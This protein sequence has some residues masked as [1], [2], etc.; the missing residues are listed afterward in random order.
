MRIIVSPAK[1]MRVYTESPRPLGTP[2]FLGDAERI[3]AWMRTLP[4]PEVK[5]LWAASDAI[6]RP[7]YDRL[8]HLD[9]T[10]PAELTPA[11]LAYDGIA[12]AYMA[13]DVFSEQDFAYVDDHLL[14]LSGLYGVL[15]PYDGVVPYRL[16]M[17][18]KAH[19]AGTRSLYDYWGDRIAKAVAAPGE[20][21][22]NLAS[23]EYSRCVER[24]LPAG[25]RLVTCT[26]GELVGG[27]VV[28]RGVYAKMA[29]GDMVRF[30]A[31][32]G[33]EGP[34]GLRSYD[35]MGYRLDEGRS[36][37]DELVFVRDGRDMRDES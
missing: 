22:V 11:L 36:D 1:K 9:L 29:R 16:E 15:R 20:T 27:R 19:V 26:F 6:A 14:I 18:A 3:L 35:R 37:A 33:V 17:Q 30:M 24:H 13:P 31:E 4:Y 34:E 12:F 2:R 25:A 5:R 21:V 23:K 28:Q 10:D 7:V 32:Q 8:P